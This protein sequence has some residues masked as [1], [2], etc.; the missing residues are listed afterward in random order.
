MYSV[1]ELHLGSFLPFPAK[2][3]LASFTFSIFSVHSSTS[4]STNLYLQFSYSKYSPTSLDLSHSNSE[5]LGF[6]INPLS[7][8]SLHSHTS[9]LPSRLHKGLQ[10]FYYFM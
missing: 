7:I 2:I 6:Q 10:L 9:W 1:Q 3:I 5:L 4:L 8:N